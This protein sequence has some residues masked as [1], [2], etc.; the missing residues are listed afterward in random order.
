MGF[1]QARTL[2]W[3]CHALLQGFF[4][5]QGLNPCLLRLLNWQVGSLPLAPPG[6][7]RLHN[8]P[9]KPQI[10]NPWLLSQ[11]HLCARR[12]RVAWLS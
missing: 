12:T 6:K 3:V 4:L 2:E 9:E 1:F 5:T 8:P 11:A 10:T 7:P